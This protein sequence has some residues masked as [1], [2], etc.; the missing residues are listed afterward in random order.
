M[1]CER[2]LIVY[3]LQYKF[4]SNNLYLLFFR[5]ESEFLSSVGSDKLLE[6]RY[7]LNQR[8]KLIYFIWLLIWNYWL[9]WFRFR[10]ILRIIFWNASGICVSI[11]ILWNGKFVNEWKAYSWWNS[12]TQLEIFVWLNTWRAISC[13]VIAISANFSPVSPCFSTKTFGTIELI[14]EKSYDKTSFWTNYRCV[15]DLL[16]SHVKC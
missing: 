4:L 7:K 11:D 15:Y 2:S 8:T 9:V 3:L 12:G 13:F 6:F 10:L 5:Y 16:Q 1:K 14:C